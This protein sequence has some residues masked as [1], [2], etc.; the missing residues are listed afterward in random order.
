MNTPCT[1]LLL[2]K[3]DGAN[4]FDV[5]GRNHRSQRGERSPQPWQICRIILGITRPITRTLNFPFKHVSQIL[6]G[7]E[8]LYGPR[9]GRGVALRSGRA[10]FQ[11][12]LREFG[13]LF[14]LTDLTFRLLPL[15]TKLKVGGNSFA[16]MFN[17]YSDQRVMVEHDA[18]HIYWH[19]TRCPMCWERHTD[20]PSAIWQSVCYRKHFIG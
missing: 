6:S 3:P 4:H 19:I 2:S 13:P 8:A 15:Q 20:A 14:G 10:C 7:L 11:Y 5:A 16:E 12:G 18:K 9:G 17:R 1:N